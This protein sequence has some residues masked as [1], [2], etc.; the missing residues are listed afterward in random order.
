MNSKLKSFDKSTT[1]ELAEYK[2]HLV[3]G[4]EDSHVYLWSLVNQNV[5]AKL[6]H[7]RSRVVV[8]VV[9]SSQSAFCLLTAH[10]SQSECCLG[11][12]Q[13]CLWQKYDQYKTL[14]KNSG[15][16]DSRFSRFDLLLILLDSVNEFTRHVFQNILLSMKF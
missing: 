3:S 2:G 7:M 1:D 4:F 13:S 11:C 14:M 6:S 8:F 16:Q 12:C 10:R 15:L 5:V 9:L